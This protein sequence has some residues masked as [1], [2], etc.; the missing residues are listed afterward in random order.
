MPQEAYGNTTVEADETVD[1]PAL[2]SVVVIAVSFFIVLVSAVLIYVRSRR[3]LSVQDDL[4]DSAEY[5]AS[6][7]FAQPVK[8]AWEDETNQTTVKAI[9]GEGS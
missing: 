4:G 2:W 8:A 7:M 6:G 3:Q 5:D 9:N 1:S